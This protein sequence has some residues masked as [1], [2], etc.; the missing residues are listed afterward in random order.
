[1]DYPTNSLLLTWIVFTPVV[2]IGAIFAVLA[3]RPALR[4]SQQAVDQAS[5][6]IGLAATVVVSLLG[7]QLW[8]GFDGGSANLQFVHHTVWMRQWNIEYFVGVDG[9]SISMVLL[10]A[11]VFLAA[12]IASLPWWGR[13]DDEHHPHFSKKR[14]PGYMILFLLLETGVLGTFCAQDFFLFYVFWEIMLL[15]MYFLIGIWGAPPRT[16]PD[17][18]VRG[19]PYAAIKF[20]LYTLAGSVL[21]MLALIAIYYA[22]GPARLVDGSL[23]DHTFN[24]V[25]L[26]EMGRNGTFDA[27]APIFGMAFPKVIF[28]ALFLGFSIKVPMFPFHTW[29]PDAHV[30]APT[31]ISVILAGILLKT[32]MYGILRFNLQMLPDTTWWAA[33]GIAL[34]G[35]ISI[36]YGAFV[37]LAQKDL[38]KLIAY[39]SVSHMG[40]CLLGMAAL[41]PQGISGSV[42][43]MV[44]HGVISPMLFLIAGVIY[45][46]AHTREINGFGG[47]AGKL[48][49]YTGLTGLAFM[50]SLGLPGLAG[51]IGE[52]LVFMGGFGASDPNFR[53]FVVAAVPAVVIT[54]GYY[55]WTMQRMFL[56]QMNTKWSH[57]WDMTWR[58]RLTLYPLAAVTILLGFWPTPVFNLVN[59]SLHHLVGVIT[60]GT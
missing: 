31:P 26:T 35:V 34:F 48:P 1:M 57:L 25:Y 58:E 40:F 17:G 32:G 6:A 38:K 29:L 27:V 45:D 15:P 44:S 52:I 22:S 13:L 14:V 18:R 54:A 60:G 2:G 30:D 59:T 56:G 5:R 39:S 47:L 43:Q 33:P 24:L 23:T 11:F 4:L 41:T 50:A 42:F 36:V 49:E 20:F 37:C 8:R 12:M 51:F 16:D 55:L 19:G 53:W 28:L 21:M 10:T 46:R 3:L 9:L 7:I